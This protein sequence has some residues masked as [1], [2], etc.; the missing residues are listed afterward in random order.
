MRIIAHDFVAA[1]APIVLTS[2]DM[3]WAEM[4]PS[5]VGILD[6]LSHHPD[7]PGTSIPIEFI[8]A[9]L[10]RQNQFDCGFCM[11]WI[12]CGF[13]W[14]LHELLSDY[15]AKPIENIYTFP[16]PNVPTT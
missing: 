13:A 4:N 2:L 12:C 9:V 15:A 1:H 5:P 6:Q 11:F 10:F 8:P 7:E 3:A 16:T 14:D